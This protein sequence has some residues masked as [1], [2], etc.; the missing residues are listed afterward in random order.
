MSGTALVSRTALLLFLFTS[1]NLLLHISFS[2]R[3]RSFARFTCPNLETVSGPP[4]GTSPTNLS[5][6]LFGIGGSAK[7]WE[8][9]SALSSLWWDVNSTRGFFWLDEKPPP[10]EKKMTNGG[11]T[12]PGISLPYR[13]SSPAWTWFRYSRLRPAVRMARI[14][15]DS[16]N[17]KLPDVRWFVMGDDDTVFFTHNLVSVLASYDHREMWYIGGNSESVE[18]SVMHGYGTAFGGGGFAVSYPLAEKLVKVLD[19]CLDRYQ[20]FYG[21]DERICACITEIGIPL[22]KEP[23]FHQFDIKG[24]A[25]GLLAAH[26]MAPLLSLHHVEALAPMFPNNTR[27]D[28]LK[29][30][31][32][33]YRLDPRR[34]LQQSVCYDGKRKWS[35]A[36]AWGY[37]IQIYPWPVTAVELLIPL[38]TFKTWKTESNGPFT[39]NTRPM[40]ADPCG[41]PVMYFLDQVEE[42]GWTGTRTRYKLE[43]WGK[44]C[45]NTA[46]YGR[47]MA[48]KNIIVTSMKMAPDY[49]EKAPRRQCCGIMGRGGKNSGNMVIR[50]RNCRQWETTGI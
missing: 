8:E 30:L 22:T 48:I 20:N 27:I 17:L 35:I 14:I 5:H 38:Q 21:S 49:W 36:V 24:D 41:R 44:S 6:L 18:Q 11:D 12:K 34:I 19:G 28:S 37:T 33:P 23:G 39:F 29:T 40:P 50:I 2:N 1:V 25:Y 47:V 10:D 3:T 13:V 7:T 31:I 42:V 32:E 46:D 4:P 43:R 16:Y 26:P 15:L 9:R 45:N